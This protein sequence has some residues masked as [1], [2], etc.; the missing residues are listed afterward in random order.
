[1][2]KNIL[3]ITALSLFAAALFAAPAT[4]R[5]ADSTN[6]PAAAGSEAPVK[7]KKH[8][9]EILPFN[10]KLTAVDQEAKTITVGDRKFEITSECKLMKGGLPATLSD[11]V[12]GEMIGG[13]YKK[14]A[15][16]KLTATSVRLGL[17]SDGA[18]KKKK[19]AAGE[20]AE[21]STNSA[22]K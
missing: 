16:G 4:A 17:K 13:A 9:A 7:H 14:N 2:R 21:T 15:D 8:Q 5:A 18:T 10:G 11:A 1:M 22:A 19:K 12:V 6:A 3:K 20:S